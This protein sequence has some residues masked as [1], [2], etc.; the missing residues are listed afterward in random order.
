[1]AQQHASLY[2]ELCGSFTTGHWIKQMV[3]AVGA[4]R[5]IYG[6]DFPFIDLR[7]ALGRVVFAQLAPDALALL[8]GGNA[9]RLLRLAPRT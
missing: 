4:D 6:S 1:M 3:A 8:L 7:Y 5:V 2:L 9:R